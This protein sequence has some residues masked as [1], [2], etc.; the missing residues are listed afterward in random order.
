[1]IETQ[2]L[3]KTFGGSQA[4]DRV[5]V[6]VPSGA[7]TALLGLNGAGKTTLLRLI[8]G[9]DRPDAGT[10][11]LDGRIPFGDPQ[12]VGVHL[13]PGALDPRHT[14]TRHLRWLAALTGVEAGRVD[15]VLEEAGLTPLRHR[16]IGALSLGARQRVAIAGALLCRPRA[17]LFDEPLNGLDVPGIVWFRGLLRRL[18]D[19]G[20]AVVVATHLL[21]EVVLS[22]DRVLM[23]RGGRVHADGTLAEVVP[24]GADPRDWLESALLDCVACA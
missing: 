12:L 4:L 16:R 11:T 5:T 2:G 10:V 24:A 21:A 17:L 23:L 14:V 6:T 22:A 7:V 18:A 20:C 9:L 3:T 19:S 15:D 1:M 8:A 13:G